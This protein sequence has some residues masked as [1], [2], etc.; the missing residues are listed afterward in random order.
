MEFL[1]YERPDGQVGIRNRLLV[2]ATCDCSYQEAKR[3][4]DS[5]SDAVAI[6]QWYGCRHDPMLMHQMI[7][8]ATNP[9]V[10]ATLLVGHGCESITVDSLMQPISQSGKP[11]ANVVC[12]RDG[13]SIKTVEKGV[14]LLRG[15]AA[16]LSKQNRHAFGISDLTVAVECGGSDAT[17]GLAANP[18]AGHV[19]DQLI[20]TG[21]TAIFSE[22]LEMVG[23]EHILARRAVNPQVAQK[24]YTMIRQ[25][26][27]WARAS[28]IPSRHMSQG[29]IDGGLSTI[30][31]K[32]LGAILKGGT[33]AIQDVLE[34]N[35]AKLERPTTPG[36]YIQN[37]IGWD[38]PSIT[39]MLAIG[40][41]IVLFTTGRGATTGHAL[42]PVIKITGNPRT[43]RNMKDNIDIN[44]GKII[45]GHAG[46]TEVA[47]EVCELMLRVA[48]G[49]HTKAEALG[50]D[51]FVM[52]RPDPVG[53]NL[54]R[55]CL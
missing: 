24:I 52:W 40:A 41:Q 2:M 51:D 18:V 9:N 37:G 30:E 6:T 5:F 8:L 7:G 1:G 19:I 23:T 17:S 43:Y 34:N 15:M 46:I 29:N 49:E 44:A 16:E 22:P 12:Q 3:I 35:R 36:L 33:R 48:S 39:H 10:G 20:D 47:T 26:E 13:G 31:E 11:L 28:G 27:K 14:R 38:V 45:E 25:T 42:A 21:G 32:S 50:Y 4:A 53:V 55:T 54:V